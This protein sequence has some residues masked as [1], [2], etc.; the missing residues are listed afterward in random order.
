MGRFLLA[1]P[2]NISLVPQQFSKV[3]EKLVLSFLPEDCPDPDKRKWDCR[4]GL[5]TP[6]P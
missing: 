5:C 3:E 6:Q 4:S 1:I 2:G